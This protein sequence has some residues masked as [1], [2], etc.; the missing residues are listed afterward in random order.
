MGTVQAVQGIH[1][2]SPQAKAAAKAAA[3]KTAAKSPE[4]KGAKEPQA[5]APLAL[6]PKTS[7]DVEA[8]QK[9]LR[10]VRPIAGHA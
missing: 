2:P 8:A 7:A 5:A 3:A 4:A 1:L 9:R 6:S 10:N